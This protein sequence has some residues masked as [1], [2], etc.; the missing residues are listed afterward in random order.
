M[1]SEKAVL[2]GYKLRISSVCSTN[3]LLEER[4]KQN[5]QSDTVLAIYILK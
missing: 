4:K 5:H 2:D 1:N 3:H